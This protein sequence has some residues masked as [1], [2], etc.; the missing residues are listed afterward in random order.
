LVPQPWVLEVWLQT[1]AFSPELMSSHSDAQKQEDKVWTKEAFSSDISHIMLEE[2]LPHSD[3]NR[4]PLPV[5]G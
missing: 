5:I 3:L 1:I 2:N 4:S